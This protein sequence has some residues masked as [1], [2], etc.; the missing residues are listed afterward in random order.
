MRNLK[1][2][3][4]NELTKQIQDHRL[5]EGTYA[6]QG[7]GLGEGTVKELG[8]DMSTLLYLK[9]I[10]YKDLLYNTENSAQCYVAA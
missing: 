3:A 7:E 8:M 4:T 6:C 2:N 5:R 9:R 1:R 10:T